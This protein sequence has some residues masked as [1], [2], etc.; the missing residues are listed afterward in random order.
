M[1]VTDILLL[2]LK[3]TSYA[4]DFLSIA[5]GARSSANAFCGARG[6]TCHTLVNYCSN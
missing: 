5:S 4:S 2:D 3:L 1:F 6:S